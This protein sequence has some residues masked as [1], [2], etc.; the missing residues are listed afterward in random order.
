[1]TLDGLAEP[2]P[3]QGIAVDHMGEIGG[4]FTPVGRVNN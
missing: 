4:S 2:V 3:Q 1:M